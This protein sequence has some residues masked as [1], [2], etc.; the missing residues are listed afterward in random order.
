M[1]LKLINPP[2]EL[3]I[4]IPVIDESKHFSNLIPKIQEVL[5]PNKINFEIIIVCRNADQETRLVI[6][7]NQCALLSP[8]G[9]G[10]GAALKAG[11]QIARGSYIITMDPDLSHS[12]DVLIPLWNNRHCADIIIASRYVNG[13]QGLMPW[14]RLVLSKILNQIFSRGLDLHVRDMSCGY[15]LYKAAIIKN[16]DLE[17]ADFDILQELLVSSLIDGYSVLEIPFTYQSRQ[18]GST[19]GRVFKF[20][21]SY[22][23][24]FS[25]LWRVRNSIQSADYDARAFHTFLPPQRYWQ[26]QR[27]KQISNIIIGKNKC[28]DVGCGSSLILAAL[29]IGSV[30][31]DI[32][33]RKLR[34]SRRYGKFTINGSALALPIAAQSFECVICSEVIE[35]IPR[36]NVFSELDRVLTPD[37]LLVLGTPDYS[38]WQ[39]LIIE[40]IY[41]LLLPQAYADEHITHYT[42]NELCNEFVIERGYKVEEIHYILQGELIISLRKP[43]TLVLD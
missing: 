33:M 43:K 21:F 22:L 40:K 8:D 7:E 4:I 41:K 34:Y 1:D 36:G 18:R 37:G 25:R 17:S 39:W 35:H 5:R 2:C 29:P 10:Y 27:V 32:Q 12:P 30:G 11:F 23:K 31:L 14:F 26:R 28:L 19:Y 13:G 3:S 20:G 16:R 24:T 38:K 15:R 42:H 9:K 6:I